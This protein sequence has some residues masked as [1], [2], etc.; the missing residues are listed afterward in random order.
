M[1]AAQFGYLDRVWLWLARLAVRR[2]SN[3]A[4]WALYETMR[5][6]YGWKGIQE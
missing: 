6:G 4:A 3:P 2:M 1:G 5:R